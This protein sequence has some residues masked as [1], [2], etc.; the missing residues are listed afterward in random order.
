MRIVAVAGISTLLI[1]SPCFLCAA[2]S[3]PEKTGPPSDFSELEKA[4]AKYRA[5]TNP[6]SEDKDSIP[7]R[8]CSKKPC[9]E[10][11]GETASGS[12]FVFARYFAGAFSSSLK[13]GRRPRFLRLTLRSAQETR[14]GN[15]QGAD[16]RNRDD[17]HSFLPLDNWL[18]FCPTSRDFIRHAPSQQKL[19]AVVIQS[20]TRLDLESPPRWQIPRQPWRQ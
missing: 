5:K 20:K 12:G 17:P 9:A 19:M 10:C 16:S 4:P 1:T 15:Q 18:T 13:S 11:H 7:R 3:K 6:L 8:F 14:T 2:Q